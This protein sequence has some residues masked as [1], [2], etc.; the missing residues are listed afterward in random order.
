[1]LAKSRSWSRLGLVLATSVAGLTCLLLPARGTTRSAIKLTM[2]AQPTRIWMRNIIVF[3][4]DSAPVEVKRLNGVLTP[5]A[6]G[7]AVSMDKV[8]S[9]AIRVSHTEVRMSAASLTALL[10]SYV[11]PSAGTDI[12]N[13]SVAFD[14]GAI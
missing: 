11:L 3:P 7:Q 10:N 1:M 12:R 4:F 5:T 13:V 2:P 6:R 8:A 9:Y 14:N